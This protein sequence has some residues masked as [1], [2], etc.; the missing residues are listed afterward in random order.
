MKLGKLLTGGGR[1]KDEVKTA[2]STESSE[3][4]D[5]SS[6]NSSRSISPTSTH[7]PLQP[8]DSQSLDTL[9][10]DAQLVKEAMKRSPETYT[11][12]LHRHHS[13]SRRETTAHAEKS[14]IN[15]NH[16]RSHSHRG[17][18][19]H[20]HRLGMA[21]SLSP[22]VSRSISPLSSRK[23][24]SPSS[25]DSS[26]EDSTLLDTNS[27]A[28]SVGSS[29]RS[30]SSITLRHA[31]IRRSRSKKSVPDARV[32]ARF[33]LKDDGIHEHH[34]RN[35]KRQE[36]LGQMVKDL[37][38]GKKL[39]NKA[40]SAIPKIL[41]SSNLEQL[42][43]EAQEA[44]DAVNHTV[45]DRKLPPTLFATLLNQVKKG[46]VTAYSHKDE[47]LKQPSHL[48][49]ESGKELT[50]SF[51]DRYGTC[52]EVVGRGSFG[53]VRVSH[54]RGVKSKEEQLF[55][56]KEFKKKPSESE[57]KYS[58]RLTNE[59]CI[60]SSL[61]HS[62]LINAYDLLRDAKGDY[63]EVM[64][65]CSGGDLYSLIIMAGRLEWA[66]ADCFFKQIMRAVHYM[67]EMGVAHRDLKPENILLTSDGTIKITDFGNAE[68][69]RIAWEDE[70]QPASGVCGSAP[71]IAPEEY[72]Q[73][74]FD[75]SAVDIWACGIIYMAMRSGRQMWKVAHP[76][77]EFYGVYLAKR[78]DAKGYEPIE[79]L[80]R[81][82]CRNVI[83]SILDPVPKRRLTA[84]QILNSEWVRQIKCC[85]KAGRSSEKV[86]GTSQK[87]AGN[88][89]KVAR[90]SE[91]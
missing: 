49:S 67:H 8:Q 29:S 77:D 70:V 26:L 38:G 78:R 11:K 91:K 75:A 41:S 43:R 13:I 62:G 79:A 89:E 24:R 15:E 51:V 66:E 61:K 19:H 36:K 18:H 35:I 50:E 57:H 20:H 14:G 69:F 3:S 65:Y 1:K 33:E 47:A 80:K 12:E 37:L 39:R 64:E 52:Q 31:S 68:C 82:R 58:R 56:V 32:L 63:C 6:A 22:S 73:P 71:Y 46:E 86:A 81:A 54:K 44:V 90:S 87:A 34:L 2:S 17:R 76:D 28:K 42:D 48:V 88:S 27:S 45:H 10:L 84:Y 7:L 25:S 55:A 4:I 74:E 5:I 59:F 21:R 30:N 9:L 83:Y 23:K 16:E 53:V 85:K 60:S 40:V 72:T